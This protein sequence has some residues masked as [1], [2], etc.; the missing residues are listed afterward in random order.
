M[1]LILATLGIA[2]VV[3]IFGSAALQSAGDIGPGG[4]GATPRIM[5]I[6][7]DIGPGGN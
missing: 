6:A 4:N 3:S 5:Y 1:R 7:G 2:L